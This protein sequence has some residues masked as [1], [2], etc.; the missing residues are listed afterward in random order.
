MAGRDRPGDQPVD[1]AVG[2]IGGVQVV[3]AQHRP[4]GVFADQR[5]QGVEVAGRRPLPDQDP[6]PGQQL[7]LGLLQAGAFMVGGDSGADVFAGVRATQT[8]G[9]PVHRVAAVERHP[10][11]RQHGRL[12]G[13]HARVVHHLGQV[14]DAW[15]VKQ[16]LDLGGVQLGAGGL[17]SG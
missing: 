15:Q 3:G 6:H 17:E 9:M 16:L 7:L 11:L 13:Q 8:G 14:A 2:Q 5:V 1:V 10:N 12:A 4:P